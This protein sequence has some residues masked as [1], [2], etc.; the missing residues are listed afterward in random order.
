MEHF[1]YGLEKVH[2][3]FVRRVKH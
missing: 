3:H 2:F 1:L